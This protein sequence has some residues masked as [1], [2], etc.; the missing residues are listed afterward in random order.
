[1]L[2][3]GKDFADLGQQRCEERQRQRSIAALRRG[4]PAFGFEI[5]PS[6]GAA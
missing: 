6:A 3:R 1:M 5:N 4:D 2:A